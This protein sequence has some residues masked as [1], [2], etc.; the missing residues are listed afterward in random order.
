MQKCECRNC[1]KEYDEAKSRA[2]Y[3][4]YCSAKCL[5]EKAR[6]LGYK[7]SVPRFDFSIPSEYKILSR[8]NAIG[9]VFIKN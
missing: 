4:G 2:D 3:K 8:A 6:A 5:H 1:R 9:S 7:R